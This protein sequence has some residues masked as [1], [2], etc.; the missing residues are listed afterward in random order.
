A[1][2]DPALPRQV[3]LA[4]IVVAVARVATAV[5]YAADEQLAIRPRLDAADA[6]HS[7]AASAIAV[8]TVAAITAAE[9][10]LHRCGALIDRDLAV[11]ATVVAIAAEDLVQHL[12]DNV[13][14]IRIAVT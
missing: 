11:G 1:V 10:R 13:T 3:D 8:V 4:L 7:R 5:G 9:P 14:A 2:I 12:T 6:E